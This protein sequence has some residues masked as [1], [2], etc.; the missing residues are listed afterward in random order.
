[1]NSRQDQIEFEEIRELYALWDLACENPA[2]HRAQRHNQY[3]I[4]GVAFLALAALIA[5]LWGLLR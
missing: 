3:F 1:M 2:E 5:V 4:S